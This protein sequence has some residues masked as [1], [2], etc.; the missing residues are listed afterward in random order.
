[1]SPVSGYPTRPTIVVEACELGEREAFVVN[2]C[3]SPAKHLSIFLCDPLGTL[4]ETTF[5]CLVGVLECV[6]HIRV[7]PEMKI[8]RVLTR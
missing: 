2:E 8:V 5:S 4:K 1:M 7:F 6:G 3:R